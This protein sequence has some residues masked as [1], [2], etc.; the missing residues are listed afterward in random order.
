MHTFYFYFLILINTYVSL[1]EFVLVY[2][3]AHEIQMR[4]SDPLGDGVP[5]DYEL[6]DVDAGSRTLVF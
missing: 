6:S 2:T 3:N 4:A 1:C 5:G